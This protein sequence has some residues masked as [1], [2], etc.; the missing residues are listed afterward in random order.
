MLYG[1]PIAA[2]DIDWVAFDESGDAVERQR[3][4]WHFAWCSAAAACRT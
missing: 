1:R 2:W 4:E 3:G